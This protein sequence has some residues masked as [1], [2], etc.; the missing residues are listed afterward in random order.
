MLAL[1]V[2]DVAV[3]R[4]IMR[5]TLRNMFESIADAEDGVIA[6]QKVKES[7]AKGQPYDVI[8]MDYLM[9]NMDGPT[10]TAAIRSLGFLGLIIGVTGN[11]LPEDI[12]AFTRS[13]ANRVFIKP[14]DVI[15]LENLL[16]KE[17][18][19]LRLHESPSYVL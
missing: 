6:L 2:D 13:G 8:F 5:K 4:K 10:A 19:G 14:L 3:N 16:L 18:E 15:A 1:I 17:R 9:P 12:D 7:I 11:A